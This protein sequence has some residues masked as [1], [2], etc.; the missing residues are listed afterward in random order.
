VFYVFEFLE[1]PLEKEFIVNKYTKCP[2]NEIT[3]NAITKKLGHYLTLICKGRRA[4]LE[5]VLQFSQE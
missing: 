3:I 5:E 4:T 1:K 2:R